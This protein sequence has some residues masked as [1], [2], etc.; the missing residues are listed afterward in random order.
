MSIRF[1]PCAPCC[2]G[3]TPPVGCKYDLTIY[4]TRHGAFA[5]YAKDLKTGEVCYWNNPV[6]NG[7]TPLRFQW[8]YNTPPPAFL[9]YSEIPPDKA[10]SDWTAIRDCNGDFTIGRVMASGLTKSSQFSAW[11]NQINYCDGEVDNTKPSANDDVTTGA[12]CYMVYNNG[13]CNVYIN[14][15]VLPNGYSCIE[16]ATQNLNTR[17]FCNLWYNVPYYDYT[18][19]GTNINWRQIHIPRH[20]AEYAGFANGDQ[21]AYPT[22]LLI[23]I[24]CC[25]PG[26]SCLTPTTNP[27]YLVLDE[28]HVFDCVPYGVG[29]LQLNYIGNNLW[30]G[31]IPNSPIVAYATSRKY[32]NSTL[33]W[34]DCAGA[35]SHA[36]ALQ[37]ANDNNRDVGNILIP[38]LGNPTFWPL[39]QP[40]PGR[41][42]Y[43][44]INHEY[45]CN[46]CA[47]PTTV[48]GSQKFWYSNRIL[49]CCGPSAKNRTYGVGPIDC[50]ILSGYSNNAPPT[51]LYQGFAL[52]NQPDRITECT[53]N[54]NLP[55]RLWLTITY[56]S[57]AWGNPGSYAGPPPGH[58]RGQLNEAYPMDWEVKHEAFT[59]AGAPGQGQGTESYQVNS[60]RAH[61]LCSTSQSFGGTVNWFDMNLVAYPKEIE[62]IQDYTLCSQTTLRSYLTNIWYISAVQRVE[63]FAYNPTY[64]YLK[65][66][67]LPP[68]EY[69]IAS[70]FPF[71]ATGTFPYWVFGPINNNPANPVG[72]SVWEIYKWQIT[73]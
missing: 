2:D 39:V 62:Y 59:L 67:N 49:D 57:G 8:A 9:Q 21:S 36:Y 65:C 35:S 58:F 17:Q 18:A 63:Q 55:K 51:T 69:H 6:P 7:G 60:W 53:E 23:D 44:D 61:V 56:H 29:N 54:Y 37:I 5:V 33:C 22:G 43:T 48:I 32:S 66:F 71:M 3:V 28:P 42:Y 64:N 14:D 10:P 27:L 15:Y 1:N 52:S 50:D 4:T 26:Q 68:P 11:Y 72:W 73:E 13:N 34:F 41:I 31:E 45:D 19:I 70:I 20:V 16:G 12:L 47:E 24:S 25:Q 46:F 40:V 30:Y 38:T